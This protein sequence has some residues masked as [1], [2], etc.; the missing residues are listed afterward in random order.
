MTRQQLLSIGPTRDEFTRRVGGK[1]LVRTYVLKQTSSPNVLP[2]FLLH[3][4]VGYR[5]RQ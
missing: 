3:P 4:D 5:A 1:L 2:L